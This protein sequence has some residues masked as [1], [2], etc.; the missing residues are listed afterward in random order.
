M[1]GCIPPPA[2]FKHVFDE[3]NLS[4]NIIFQARHEYVTV[5]RIHKNLMKKLAAFIGKYIDELR[6]IDIIYRYRKIY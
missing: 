5:P 6:F 2:I 3:Y 1:W 4:M